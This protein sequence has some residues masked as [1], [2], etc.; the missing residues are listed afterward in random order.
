MYYGHQMSPYSQIQ[1]LSFPWVCRILQETTFPR[2]PCPLCSSSV[3][4]V[5]STSG[6]LEGRRKGAPREFLPPQ[7]LLLMAYLIAETEQVPR[8]PL[9]LWPQL[10]WGVPTI[11][12]I[13]CGWF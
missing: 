1:P 12:E 11:D 10:C 13:P 7:P 6:R 2:L 4:P 8:E 5:R 9:L 3:W